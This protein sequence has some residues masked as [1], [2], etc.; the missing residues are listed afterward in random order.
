MRKWSTL[1]GIISIVAAFLTFRFA[2][3]YYERSI[4]EVTLPVLSSPAQPYT[5]ISPGIVKEKRFPR[6]I[7]SLPVIRGKGEIVGKITVQNI[8][9]D[10]P[11]FH[12]QVSDPSSFRFTSDPSLEVFSF[13]IDPP[14]AVGGQIRPGHRINIYAT[15]PEKLERL[16]EGILVVD[17]RTASGEKPEEGKVLNIITVA[18][19]QDTIARILNSLREERSKLWVTL[20]PL[21]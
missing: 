5:I 12:Y 17:V 8:P 19:P 16:G 4:E 21:K 20:A 7:L 1:F 2:H 14:R 15:G 6:A 10:T 9:S 3:S 18:A 11:I 13:P